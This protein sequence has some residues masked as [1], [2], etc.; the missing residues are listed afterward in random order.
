MT[1]VSSRENF[2]CSK[3]SL[4]LTNNFSQYYSP[5]IS[6]PSEHIDRDPSWKGKDSGLGSQVSRCFLLQTLTRLFYV[7]PPPLV[8]STGVPVDTGK[9]PVHSGGSQVSCRGKGR[10]IPVLQLELWTARVI[11]MEEEIKTVEHR[12]EHPV[13]LDL[14]IHWKL[15]IFSHFQMK[16]SVSGHI[17]EDL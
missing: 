17:N 4:N 13:V 5:Y 12:R 16:D 9:W 14:T 6:L 3:S 10:G 8:E 1:R 7:P 2:A 11:G 15:R